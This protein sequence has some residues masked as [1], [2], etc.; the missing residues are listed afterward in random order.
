MK[1]AVSEKLGNRIQVLKNVN[2]IYEHIPKEILPKDYGGN[3]KNLSEL[4]GKAKEEVR[5][6]K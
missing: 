3:E 6:F 4:H 2:A 5:Y 1:Q